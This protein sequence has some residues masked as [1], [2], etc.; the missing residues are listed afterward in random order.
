MG[1]YGMLK[2]SLTNHMGKPSI[3]Y[4]ESVEEALCFGWIDGIKKTIDGEK[5]C[6]RFSPRKAKSHW[7]A[8][9]ISRAEK[10]IDAGWACRI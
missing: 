10:L 4:A 8:L 3:G 2:K 5:Y 1:S 9:N 7:S 6:H